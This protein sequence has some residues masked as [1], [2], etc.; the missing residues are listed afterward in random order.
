MRLRLQP[1]PQI[2]IVLSLVGTAPGAGRAF[3]QQSSPE[4]STP[5][6]PAARPDQVGA[7]AK[8]QSGTDPDLTMRTPTIKVPVNLV[9]MPVTVLDKSGELV[10]GLSQ[11]DF[12]VYDNGTPQLVTEFQSELVALSVVIIVQ[13]NDPT[14]PLLDQVQPLGPVFTDLL[15]GAEGQ[16][17]VITFDDRVRVNQDFSS[18][19]DRLDKSLKHLAVSGNGARLNDA[20]WRAL[21]LIETRPRSDRRVIIAFSDGSDSGS[22]THSDAIIRRATTDGVGIYGLGFSPGQELFSNPAKTQH[23]S[24]QDKNVS[25]P[26]PSGMPPT[27]SASDEIY[28]DPIEGLPPLSE[29]GRV[30]KSKLVKNLLELYAGYTGGVFHSHWKDRALQN[31]LQQ[32]ASEI[33]SQYELGYVPNTLAQKGFH[34]LTV[35]V[36]R[37]GVKVRTR[38]GYF[39]G[40]SAP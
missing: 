2:L 34:R 24:E 33:H 18:D 36:D 35:Q 14:G 20:L 32:M 37:R 23:V 26:L 11:G 30:I 5:K 38:A 22:K 31:Q 4:P 1:V 10:Y 12:Q 19:A 39:Y 13:T 8:T 16:A 25:R 28:G 21:S 7:G 6:D 3:A 40:G 17:A 29:A 15:L 9:L 27:P